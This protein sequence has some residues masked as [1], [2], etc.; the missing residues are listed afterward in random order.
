V[1]GFR[2]TTGSGVRL[3]LPAAPL[4]LPADPFLVAVCCQVGGAKMVSSFETSLPQRIRRLPLDDLFELAAIKKVSAP[5]R[6]ACLRISPG[7]RQAS[8]RCRG[9]Q[10]SAAPRGPWP[11]LT[12]HDAVPLHRCSLSS[13]GV[14]WCSWWRRRTGTS[15]T[16]CPRKRACARWS[17]SAW[18]SPSRP[19]SSV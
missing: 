15:R 10:K 2:L 4:L 1:V 8:H 17:K 3:C 12:G 16:C 18:T 7:W 9:N 19:P 14:A 5:P 11:L 6:L 13:C